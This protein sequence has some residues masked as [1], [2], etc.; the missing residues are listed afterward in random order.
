MAANDYRRKLADFLATQAETSDVTYDQVARAQSRE[1]LGISSLNM[2]LVLVN[3][4]R[5]HTNGTVA[6]DP[7][8][9]SRL[10]DVDGIVSVLSEIDAS[11]L[12]R[13]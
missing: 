9:V 6:L 5:E 7:E 10:D 2:V 8:W 4:I 13:A 3:Y 1:D 12:A 11:M